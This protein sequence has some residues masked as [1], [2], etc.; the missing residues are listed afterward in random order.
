MKRA[1]IKLDL[2]FYFE[3]GEHMWHGAFGVDPKKRGEFLPHV[4]SRELF[5]DLKDIPFQGLRCYV[6]NP[7]ERYLTERYG[8]DW[9]TPNKGYVYWRDCKAIDRNFFKPKPE[10][11][12]GG[13]WGLFHVG[14]VRML[15]RCKALARDGRLTV[16]VLT[17]EA[18]GR[19]KPRPIIPAK[20]RCSVIE[21]LKCV[22]T[23]IEQN[24][25]DP[26]DDFEKLGYTPD[27][28]V[29]GDDWA[30]V[31]GEAY[32]RMHGG[33][34][35][36]LPYTPG[37]SSTDIKRRISERGIEEAPKA[38]AEKPSDTIAVGIKTFMRAP[39]LYRALNELKKNC[40]VS[41]RLYI[42][43]DGPLDDEKKYRYQKLR[44][45]GHTVIT[46]PFNSGISAGRNAI[47]KAFK[48]DYIL[49]ADDDV[50]LADLDALPKMRAV[51]DARPDIG[52]VAA[53]IR[54][55][56]GGDFASEGYAKGIRFEMAG[57]LLKR[58]PASQKIERVGDDGP[59]YVVADQ[60]SNF[61]L[62]R[63]AV[64]DSVQWDSRIKIEF[65]HM[66]FFLD[67]QKTPWKAAV[68][69]DAGAVHLVS[70]P[71]HE[72]NVYRRTASPAYFFQR[73]GL[74]G[75]SNQF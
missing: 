24:D 49:I 74:S 40:P 37:V 26:S 27:Y 61:F 35:V 58:L 32:V 42:A 7:P 22:D 1:G 16:G 70:T 17:D 60:V 73:Y 75:V 62:A 48:E 11:F 25:T 8:P 4:F 68:C 66:A 55:E 69:L 6:P 30:T 20:D 29:H 52:L 57:H 34:A 28:I 13:V 15:E 38:K 67:L 56:N 43:D 41:Y 18:A 5:T 51:L 19:Y 21:S 65:E 45:E 71:E 64:F 53:V 63:R 10:V 54:G 14:H 46:L 31:P 23:A 2:F 44:D 50:V 47:I 33:K 9:K 59:L 72:Y 39:T 3:R 12:I 36:I